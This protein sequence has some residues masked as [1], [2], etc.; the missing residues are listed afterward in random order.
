MKSERSHYYVLDQIR[1]VAALMVVIV[2][3]F[4][5]YHRN[6]FLNQ[7]YPIA[8]LGKHGVPIFFALSGYLLGNSVSENPAKSN[9]NFVIRR[10]LRIY[11]AYLACLLILIFVERPDGTQILTH[12]TLL[13]FLF[14]TTFGGINYPFWS[15][16]IEMVYYMLIPSFR[17]MGNRNLWRWFVASTSLSIIWQIVGGYLRTYKSF[18]TNLDWMARL[19]P[20]TGISAFF[21]GFMYKRNMFTLRMHKVMLTSSCLMILIEIASAIVQTQG[22]AVE[23]TSLV[24][25]ILHGSIGY[26]VYGFIFVSIM[27][28]YKES[29]KE[30]NILGNIGRSSYSLYLWHLPVLQYISDLTNANLLLLPIA[31]MAIVVASTLS[32]LLIELPF[33][34]ISKKFAS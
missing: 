23:K 31:L 2:H 8:E 3:I 1:A 14:G 5:T 20:L 32:Y 26:L 12:L 19:Y 27:D 6:E 25:T 34:N 22:V 15:L 28:K 17:K 29:G 4:Q 11:P 21:I 30:L 18:D 33:V 7:Y 24:S 16:S 9:K 10:F 13:Q